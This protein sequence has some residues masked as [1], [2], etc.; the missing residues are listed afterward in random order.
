LFS[1]A[2]VNAQELRLSFLHNKKFGQKKIV[3]NKETQLTKNASG[4]YSET[5]GTIRM[6]ETLTRPTNIPPQELDGPPLHTGLRKAATAIEISVELGAVTASISTALVAAIDSINNVLTG[7]PLDFAVAGASTPATAV[8]HHV[9]LVAQYEQ[10]V[11]VEEESI[12]EACA[13]SLRS[14]IEA[15]KREDMIEDALLELEKLLYIYEQ[16]NGK[17]TIENLRDGAAVFFNH[18]RAYYGAPPITK[19]D[20]DKPFVVAIKDR[21]SGHVVIA[22]R[23]TLG[24]A[25]LKHGRE[26]INKYGP[27][28]RHN[29]P[30]DHLRPSQ[31]QGGL[32]ETPLERVQRHHEDVM[33]WHLRAAHIRRL[34]PNGGLV[35][36]NLLREHHAFGS[37]GFMGR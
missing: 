19:R 25:L 36:A 33:L 30:L 15:C 4:I 11:E 10:I 34:D 24:E 28:L 7:R 23:G 13:E 3:A 5:R 22:F 31:S 29:A 8:A 21:E 16:Q 12:F 14:V 6:I 37:V 27:E 1:H 17:G 26:M 35:Q 9:E 18:V 32:G 20:F 2:A